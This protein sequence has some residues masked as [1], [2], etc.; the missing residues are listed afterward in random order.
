MK[1]SSNDL[2]LLAFGI[3]LPISFHLPYSLIIVIYQLSPINSILI[4]ILSLNSLLLTHSHN[5]GRTLFVFLNLKLYL[6]T[7]TCEHSF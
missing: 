6:T 5:K 7:L 4:F 2:N 3:L 1:S